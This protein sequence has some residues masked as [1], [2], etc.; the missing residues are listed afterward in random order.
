MAKEKYRLQSVLDVRDRAKQDAARTV[1]ARRAQLAE[2]EAELARRE[3]AVEDCRARQVEA[4]ARM[5]EETKEGAEAHR[6]VAHR[7]HLT[8]LRETEAQLLAAVG[9][10]KNVVARAEAEV[11]KA[12]AALVEAAKE[13]QV[14]E[15]H[16]ETWRERLRRDGARR[17]QKLNDEIG[18]IL[19]ERHR[20]D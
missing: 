3:Q 18:A 6:L 10:Q 8:D 1:A 4:R 20:Q 16:R 5:V 7:T 17:E 9:Q 15:K 19:R 13:L 2:A 11:E 14:M 12:L